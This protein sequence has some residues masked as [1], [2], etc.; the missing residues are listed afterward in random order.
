MR[1]SCTGWSWNKCLFHQPLLIKASWCTSLLLCKTQHTV[2]TLHKQSSLMSFLMSSALHRPF[3]LPD[4]H[5]TTTRALLSLLFY[6]FCLSLSPVP[7]Q[8]FTSHGSK[9]QAGSPLIMTCPPLSEH[10][11]ASVFQP[12]LQ[13]TLQNLIKHV[14]HAHFLANRC[15]HLK[16]C[17]GGLLTPAAQWNKNLCDCSS[18]CDYPLGLFIIGMCDPLIAPKQ[19]GKPHYCSNPLTMS[20]A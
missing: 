9:G 18:P 3:I 7:E 20:I 14:H 6:F 8:A 5:S 15:R 4:A 16:T 1:A 12:L 10:D 17:T 2:T 11:S 19:C 13:H